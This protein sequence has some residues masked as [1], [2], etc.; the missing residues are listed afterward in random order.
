MA[1]PKLD[2]PL[3]HVTLPV[4]QQKISFRACKVKEEKV[5]LTGKEGDAKAQLAAMKQLLINCVVEPEEFDP[6]KLTM[7]DV[8]YMF[9]QLRAR[10]VQNIVELKYRDKEDNKVY[11]FEVDLDQIVPTI[12]EDRSS[13]IDLTD[14]VGIELT[15]PTLD[16]ITD[17]DMTNMEDSENA[18]K[19]IAA[20]PVQ[21]WDENEV[22]DDFTASELIDFLQGMDIKMF[23]KMKD[24]FDTAP[25]MTHEL[26]YVNKEGNDRTIKLEGISDFF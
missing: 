11:D 18:Y 25:K 19:V 14:T 12:P 7:P 9:I 16:A 10:S 26:N 23:S 21:V 6:G 1:L 8:E 20:C 13:K 24:F 22:Y 2:T 4:S 5:L 3:Y 17:I 15:D